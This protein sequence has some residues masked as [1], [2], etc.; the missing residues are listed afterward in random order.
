MEFRHASWWNDT[1]RATFRDAGIIFCTVSA[2][3][4]P[5]ELMVTGDEV[6]LRFHGAENWYRDD[7]GDAVLADWA[8]RIGQS[9]AK[10]VWAYFNNT[11]RGHAIHNAQDLRQRL[12]A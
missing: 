7:Y 5:D 6:Y 12:S 10:R 4:L 11:M 3:N 8:D 2:P 1:V 9:G